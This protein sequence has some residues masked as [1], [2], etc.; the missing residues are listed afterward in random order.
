MFKLAEN[1]C[2]NLY[3]ILSPIAELRKRW[4]A[5]AKTVLTQLKSAIKPATTLYMP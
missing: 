2:F 4:V 5:V 3:S 1:I